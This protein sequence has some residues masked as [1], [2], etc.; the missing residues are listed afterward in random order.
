M[1]IML[2]LTRLEDAMQGILR[3]ILHRIGFK[4]GSELNHK[5]TNFLL[6]SRTRKHT[7]NNWTF[8][9]EITVDKGL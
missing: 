5:K 9:G 4:N 2:F 6:L 3:N 8:L 7:K 1:E